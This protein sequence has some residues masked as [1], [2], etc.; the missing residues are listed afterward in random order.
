M[1][2][3][4]TSGLK[5]PKADGE[6]KCDTTFVEDIFDKV[7]NQNVKHLGNMSLLDKCIAL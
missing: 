1:E 3:V 6:F 7:N 5:G 4:A 2:E